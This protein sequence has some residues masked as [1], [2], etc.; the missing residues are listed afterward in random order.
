MFLD[1]KKSVGFW[2]VFLD[3]GKCFWILGSAFG[4][5]EVFRIL[6]SVFGFWE[7]LLDSGKCFGFWEVFLDSGK[8]FW[9]LESA[10]GFWDVFRVLEGVS[11]SGKCF[12]ILGIALDSG[13]CFVF[14]LQQCLL[15][16]KVPVLAIWVLEGAQFS[17]RITTFPDF[18]VR[19]VSEQPARSGDGQEQTHKT[20]LKALHGQ[21]YVIRSRP[22][23]IYGPYK[24][25]AFIPCYQ[26]K[27]CKFAH[28]E[29]ERIAWEEDRKKG[30]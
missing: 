9:I 15:H 20:S 14:C 2:K 25:C 10:F 23:G 29:V 17:P 18:S 21:N 3:S 28:S 30:T 22:T 19:A 5:W 1:S 13:K 4:F 27:L 7:V 11:D 8:C 16:N 26:G 12:W 6:G 24:L